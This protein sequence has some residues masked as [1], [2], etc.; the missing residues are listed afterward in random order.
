MLLV[1][2]TVNLQRYPQLRFIIAET[3]S[4]CI[5]PDSSLLDFLGAAAVELLTKTSLDGAS[6]LP[7]DSVMPKPAW[8]RHSPLR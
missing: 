6:P 4:I 7:L 5:L 1:A 8:S 2:G 3:R